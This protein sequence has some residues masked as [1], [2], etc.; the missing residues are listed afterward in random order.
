MVPEHEA[1]VRR[2]FDDLWSDGDLS[3]AD[4]VLAPTHV[5]H[6]GDDTVVGPAALKDM[7]ARFRTAFPD[8]HFELEDVVSDADRVVVRWT[9]TGTHEGE[10]AGIEATGR[11]ARWTGIDLVRLEEGRIVELWASADGAGLFEQLTE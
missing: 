3:C 2:F 6:V 11:S 10:F 4:E 7:V 8:L 5:H 1:T 9:A